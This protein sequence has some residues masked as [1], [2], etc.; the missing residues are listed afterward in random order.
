MAAVAVTDTTFDAPS[1]ATGVLSRY[2]LAEPVSS[3]FWSRGVNDTYRVTSGTGFMLRIYRKG[4]RT[5][6]QIDW[7]LSLLV[8]LAAS[9][10]AVSTPVETVDGD[11]VQLIA[12]PEGVRPAVLFT[13]AA[14]DV[15][16][17]TAD[18]AASYGAAAAHLHVGLDN[19]SA[20]R[21]DREPL[22]LH[23]LLDVPLELIG[24]SITDA[25][26]LRELERT[27][28][29]VRT[30]I[31][32]RASHLEWAA[33]HGDLHGGNAHRSHDGTVT[34][35][36]FDCGGLGWRAYDL[37]VY[38]WSSTAM[39]GSSGTDD[40]WDAFLAAYRSIRSLSDGDIDAIRFFVAARHIWY[41]GLHARLLPVIGGSHLAPSVLERRRSVL[42]HW[43]EHHLQ[44]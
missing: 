28:D 13:V 2:P 6:D 1:L 38:R 8:A 39:A 24:T 37:A 43:R 34:F 40:R 3:Q 31:E 30:G 26:L 32:A 25:G 41:L 10:A 33:C 19:V 11:L 22:D 15:L 35:F 23:H 12:A 42:Q 20:L 36:D 5:L 18:G 29:L 9:G 17:F 44:D 16:P 14:G 7:E 4:W 21:G 27:A